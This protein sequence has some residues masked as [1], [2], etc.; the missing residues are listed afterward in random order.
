MEAVEMNQDLAKY[1]LTEGA[2]LVLFNVPSGTEFGI[3]MK[4]WNTGD[5]FKGIKMIPPGLHYVFYSSVS[6]STGDT[7]HRVGFLHDFKSKEMVIK[8]WD[9]ELEELTDKSL[10]DEEINRIKNNLLE[11]DR[12]LGPYPFEIYDMWKDLTDNLTSEQAINLSPSCGY[13]KSALE[14]QSCNDNDRPKGA[15]NTRSHRKLNWDISDEE[16]F[17]PNLHPLPGTAPRLS[18]LPPRCPENAKP[19]EITKYFLDSTHSLELLLRS[20]D[21][22]TD[23]IGELQFSFVIFLIGHSVE[24]FHHWKK[25]LNILC[26][27]ELALKLHT[28]MYLQFLKTLH[29]HILQVPNEFLIDIVDG[30]NFLYVKSRQLFKNIYSS[31]LTV[32]IKRVDKM[33]E[34]FTEK[35]TWNFEDLLEEDQ[36]DL[37]VVVEL[38]D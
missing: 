37:P 24:G 11:L 17:L 6:E 12:Y 30:N 23:V 28:S 21:R 10:S 31:G 26:T 36:E 13:I 34:D 38:D 16:G 14:L 15:Q 8:F 9:N 1:L 3:D 18:T 20:Y 2:S 22:P 7:G 29:T 19:E 27:S 33:M 4:S 25:L 35:F 5:Q 32:L